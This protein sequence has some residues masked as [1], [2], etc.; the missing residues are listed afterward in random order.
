[1]D[2]FL[3]IYHLSRLS[4]EVIQNLNTAITS[5]DTVCKSVSKASPTI[6]YPVPDGL[7]MNLQ[8]FKEKLASILLKLF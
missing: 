5:K 4:L 7:L 1:M 8:I 2:K 3:E 6:K